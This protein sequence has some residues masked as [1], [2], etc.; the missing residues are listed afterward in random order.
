MTHDIHITHIPVYDNI[1]FASDVCKFL[2][3]DD[4]KYTI[5]I[6]SCSLLLLVMHRNISYYDKIR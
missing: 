4:G 2:S 1:K 5:K 3:C 6:N